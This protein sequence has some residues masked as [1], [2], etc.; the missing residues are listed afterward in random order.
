MNE[1]YNNFTAELD[2]YRTDEIK[3]SR[4][5]DL[6][7]TYLWLPEVEEVR[8]RKGKII[9]FRIPGATRGCVKVDDNLII[10]N[11][12]FYDDTCF[13]KGLRCYKDDIKNV[14]PKL[15]GTKLE[16]G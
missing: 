16:V 5:E 6:L 8:E 7:R 13:A 3:N 4:Y 1:Y 10:E 12:T 9:A 11:I 15:I 14:V 2:K